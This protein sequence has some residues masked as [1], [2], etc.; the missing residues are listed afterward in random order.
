MRALNKRLSILTELEHL[1]LYAFPDF[2][3]IQRKQFF[4]FTHNEIHM[5]FSR[6]SLEKQIYCALQVG[7]F[8]AKQLFFSFQWEDIPDEDINF[9]LKRYFKHTIIQKIKI[10]KHECYAQRSLILKLFN[11]KKWSKQ[12][13]NI[14][15]EK[16]S[17]I[18]K[19]DIN[20]GFILNELIVFLRNEKIIR[21]NHT[22]LQ[23]IISTAINNEYRRLD[24]IIMRSLTKNEIQQLLVLLEEEDNLSNLTAIKQDSKDFKYKIILNELD[25]L[26]TLKPL[27][28]KA[29]KIILK[30]ET[31]K[32]NIKYYADLAIFYT[33]YELRRLRKSL[34]LLY[35]I[36]YIW[37][38][39]QQLND[40]ILDAFTHFVNKFY[41][42]AKEYAKEKSLE[43]TTQYQDQLPLVGDI[44]N[45]F[46]EDHEEQTKF[47]A[48]KDRAFKIIEKD[49]LAK[50]IMQ[51]KQQEGELFYRWQ[52]IALNFLAISKN[53]YP[54]FKE[55]EFTSINND[56]NWSNI[57]TALQKKITTSADIPTEH[58]MLELIPKR[59]RPYLTQDNFSKIN[60]KNFEFWCYL[61]II[62][63]L[64]GELYLK[65]SIR[66]NHLN[67]ELISLR[68]DKVKIERLDLPPLFSIDIR[69]HLKE[70]LI[71]LDNAWKMFNAK[72]IQDDLVHLKFNFITKQ[73]EWSKPK[74]S[75]KKLEERTYS[76]FPTKDIVEIIRFVDKE[77]NF[78]SYFTSLQS[79]YTK[80]QVEKDT[81]I[82]CL[83]SKALNY[84]DLK[85]S[86]ASDISYHSIDYT[87]KQYIRV[88][89]LTKASD[90]VSNRIS[91]LEAFPYYCFEMNVLYGAVDGQKYELANTTLNAR[92]S[93]KHKGKGVV[94]YTLL[95]NHIPLQT[96][97]IGNH[98]HE[99]Y[100]V[101]DI[102][103]SNGTIIQPT[104]IS[105]DMHSINKANF[106][107]LS[108]FGYEFT[109]RFANIHTQIKH[110]YG[111]KKSYSYKKY[112]VK[113]VGQLN[114]NVIID[115]WYNLKRV[116]ATLA[117]KETTQS[118]IIR[119]LCTY[120]HL[121][122]TR[123]ALFE[124]DKLLRSIYTLK[125]LTNLDLQKVVN[126][127]QNRLESYHNLRAAI[128]KV[129]GRKELRG[130]TD[131]EI[132]ESNLCGRLLANV[133][134]YYNSAIISA[135]FKVTENKLSKDRE[136][137][138][139]KLKKI[140]PVAWQHINLMGQ[141][142][143][144]NK[145][146][147][148]INIQELI[149]GFKL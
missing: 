13:L 46:L 134:I 45:L 16:L 103:Q 15:I 10:S 30:L 48:I 7:Y 14:T 59:L 131:I 19:Q 77:T 122:Q 149:K 61:K 105:G 4:N 47:L 29:N 141:Y 133:I 97:V 148:T 98:E 40:N 52:F 89:T 96:Q 147:H 24:N 114:K 116:M 58:Y 9:L 108:W 34:T 123:R 68:R 36:C 132:E 3:N 93:K 127:S 128:A 145:D 78:L 44:L 115:G 28:K 72:L 23:S 2:N 55:L 63:N 73:L 119:K 109:P 81:L 12:T 111:T 41:D 86:E 6:S 118:N 137:I 67:K 50:T 31:S 124:Y 53:V 26:N 146:G 84:G 8:K 136:R 37:T 62:Y 91:E 75:D 140:S 112:L 42:K 82:A 22:T 69:D 90:V 35:L 107:I 38:R 117:M 87:S 144:T 64:K 33:V 17:K 142:N 110:L 126:S 66:N 65:D 106:A 139:R 95:C 20:S 27:Y 121:D 74:N 143:F 92:Y 60:E 104:A 125:Y 5:I 135:L 80:G 79:K 83:L 85:I 120:I 70:K 32:Q 102:L 49:S 57:I 56:S 113:P 43:S 54:L 21:P 71:D 76:Q 129:G 39:Y 100:F 88:A 11:Y 51:L 99:S 25:K 130:K 138:I 94:A 18:T 1:A 101:F